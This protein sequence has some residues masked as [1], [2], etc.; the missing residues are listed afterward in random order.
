MLPPWPFQYQ[1]AEP[2]ESVSQALEQYSVRD[3]EDRLE[4][5]HREMRELKKQEGVWQHHK[6]TDPLHGIQK[7][8]GPIRHGP[9]FY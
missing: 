4:T 1:H 7:M 5:K 6:V 3:L 8:K 9:C 2:L